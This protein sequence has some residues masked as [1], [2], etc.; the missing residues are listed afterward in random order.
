[1]AT[2]RN[3]GVRRA[4][5]EEYF[6]SLSRELDA[7]KDRV[8]YL[9]HDNHWQTDGEWKES[10]LRSVLQRTVPQNMA[11]GRG[12]IVGNGGASSQIDILVYDTPYP[13]LYK[14]GDLV[15]ISPSSCRAI[16]EV[17]TRVTSAQFRSA[18]IKLG[19]N[20]ALGRSGATARRTVFTGLFVYEECHL[21]RLLENVASAA[22]DSHTRIVDHVSIGSSMFAKF[23]TR[24]PEDGT[25]SYKHWHQY[26]LEAMAQD[27][28]AHN[29]S[30]SLAPD[31]ASR[32]EQI[33]FPENGKEGHLTERIKF[34][35]LILRQFNRSHPQYA[36]GWAIERLNWAA[37]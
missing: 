28:F 17:K 8:R 10:V 16:I 9:I 6:R 18:L 29:L 22:G 4:Q 25:G 19:D 27:Y 30:T 11:I 33:W 14:D 12:F 35:V 24:N 31:A 7:L 3:E 13:V 15:F 21:P 37:P 36:A 26:H 5:I 1:M 20:A 34:V 23:W 32:S 2:R